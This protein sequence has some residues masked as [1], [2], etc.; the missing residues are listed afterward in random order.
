V[1]SLGSKSVAD[2]LSVNV[3]VAVSPAFRLPLSLVTAIVGRTVS[4][5]IVTVLFVSD[6]SA[7]WFPAASVNLLLD[8]LTTPLAVLPAVGVNVAV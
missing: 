1:R 7:F 6:P 2:S 4:T 5:L 3:T 8:T